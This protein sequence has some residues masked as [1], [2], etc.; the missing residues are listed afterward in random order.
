MEAVERVL[1]AAHALK[2][3]GVNRYAHRSKP[4]LAEERRRAE[5]RRAHE[6]SDL[7]R[8]VAHRARRRDSDDESDEDDEKQ[9]QEIKRQSSGCPRRTC[10]IS[11]K[12]ARRAWTTGSAS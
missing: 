1:D 3:H 4:N 11:S 2:E 5:E 12:S 10:S 8:S 9:Q 7:Q 6:R